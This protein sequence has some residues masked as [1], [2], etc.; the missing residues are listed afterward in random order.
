M[1]YGVGKSMGSGGWGSPGVLPQPAPAPAPAPPTIPPE[2][3]PTVTG[4]DPSA[5]ASTLYDKECPVFLGGMAAIGM[6][7]IEGPVYDIVDNENVVS[8]V[9]AAAINM[10]Y[11]N[12]ANLVVRE[13]RFRGKQAW[14]LA[15]GVLLSGLTI[16]ATSNS[17]MFA[18]FTKGSLTQAPDAWSVSRFASRANA[19]RPMITAT[20][21]KIRLSLF[22]DANGGVLIPFPTLV[23]ADSTF[24]TPEDGI[25]YADAWPVITKFAGFED[26]EVEGVNLTG[27]RNAFF[28]ATKQT[29]IQWV[30]DHRQIKRYWSLRLKDKLYL[31]EKA[32]TEI[33]LVVDRTMVSKGGS[34]P[35]LFTWEESVAIARK[36]NLTVI[37]V[38]RDYDL[39]TVAAQ[40]EVAPVP[41][42]TAFEEETIELADVT[43]ASTATAEVNYALYD[44]DQARDKTEY[45]G[46]R[47]IY[48]TEAGDQHRIVTDFGTF[49]RRV[50]EVTRNVGCSVEIKTEGMLTCAIVNDGEAASVTYNNFYELFSQPQEATYS[51]VDIGEEAA[52]RVVVIVTGMVRASANPYTFTSVLVNG[53]A[54]TIHQQVAN[55]L[56]GP[57]GQGPTLAIASCVVPSGTSATVKV[58]VS[59]LALNTRWIAAYSL[60]NLASPTPTDSQSIGV[61]ASD[62]SVAIDVPA[63]GVLIAAYYGSDGSPATVTWTGVTT[64]DFDRATTS[65]SRASGASQ[66]AMSSQSNRPVSATSTTG[67]A[68]NL[69]AVTWG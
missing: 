27:G 37:D 11:E 47:I 12:A 35:F 25:S 67:G 45:T 57:L 8:W 29:V 59:G 41:A 51:G 4:V 28:F 49:I 20:F 24:G 30:N 23:V 43:D 13:L 10:N 46:K 14:T 19:Y 68:E 34:E 32:A 52:D 44:E 15:D 66:S 50:E 60:Y 38:A 5:L 22:K 36:K 62:P 61:V 1:A 33:D 58:T 3:I 17:E 6:R 26:D 56:N 65:I 39:N 54:A 42:T 40:L 55:N 7:I 48:G 16:G 31:V 69:V 53:I 9:A 21:E 64:K 2:T 18:R 63:N